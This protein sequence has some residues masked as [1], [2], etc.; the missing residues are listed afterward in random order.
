MPAITVDGTALS[1][2]CWFAVWGFVLII[3]A[4]FLY[5][6]STRAAIDFSALVQTAYDLYR[7]DLIKKFHLKVPG[8]LKKEKKLWEEINEFIVIGEQFHKAKKFKY[9]DDAPT[10]Q[11]HETEPD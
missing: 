10:E 9:H 4:Y 8:T 11:S 5:F 6:L 1:K 3:I 2:G 7:H